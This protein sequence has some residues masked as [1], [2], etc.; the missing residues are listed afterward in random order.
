MFTDGEDVKRR[1][2]R[3]ARKKR[4]LQRKKEQQRPHTA[5]PEHRGHCRKGR[6]DSLHLVGNSDKRFLVWDK[7]LMFSI[8]SLKL[9]QKNNSLCILL[10]TFF[11]ILKVQTEPKGA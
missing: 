3:T 1:S 8:N 5:K 4:L 10:T 11:L 2:Q 9:K 7:K 6:T